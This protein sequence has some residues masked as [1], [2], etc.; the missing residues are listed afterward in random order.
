LLRLLPPLLHFKLHGIARLVAPRIGFDYALRDG[1]PLIA[2]VQIYH[3]SVA[4][5]CHRSD[6]VE[7]SCA[8]AVGALRVDVSYIVACCAII[9]V[10]CYCAAWQRSLNTRRLSSCSRTSQRQGCSHSQHTN[11]LSYH[12]RY[13]HRVY[14]LLILSPFQGCVV[15]GAVCALACFCTFN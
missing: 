10:S 15:C 6:A 8:T 14:P 12:F 11:N 13:L 7:A 2:I 4:I 5:R 3:P 9:T 1:S